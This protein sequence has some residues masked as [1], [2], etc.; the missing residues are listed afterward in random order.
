MDGLVP[1]T[2]ESTLFR[3]CLNLCQPEDGGDKRARSEIE[4]GMLK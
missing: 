1:T 2:T 4:S 3:V